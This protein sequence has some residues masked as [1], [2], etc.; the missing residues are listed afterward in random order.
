MTEWIMTAM[1][2]QT[3]T[4]QNAYDAMKCPAGNDCDDR[5]KCAGAIIGKALEPLANGKGKIS[6]LVMLG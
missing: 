4:M 2:R 6:V 3:Q 5:T 1:I